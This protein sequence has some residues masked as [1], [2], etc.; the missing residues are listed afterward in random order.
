[1]RKNPL[2]NMSA[3]GG[4]ITSEF[5]EIICGEKVANPKVQPESFETFSAEAPRNKAELDQWIVDSWDRLRERWDSLSN[6]YLKMN[7]SDARSKWIVP[8]FKELGFDPGFI[9]EEIV[10]DGDDKLRFRLSHRGWISAGA[11]MLHMVAPSQD[12]EEANNR[13]EGEVI[14]R[15]RSRSPHDELQAYLN[16]NKS[17]K[18]G[19]VTNGILLR[20]LREYYHTTTKGYVEFDIENIFRERSF[21]DFRAMYRMAHASRFVLQKDG[22]CILEQ[23]YKESR[24]AGVTVGKNLRLNV[25]KAIEALGNGFLT[26]D[27][28][29]KMIADEEFCRAYYSEL[30]HVVY[31]LLF[32][33]FAEQRAMLPTRDSLY[34]EEYSVTRLREISETKRGKDDHLDLW[35]GLKVTFQMLKNGCPELKV[36]G[37]NGSLFDDA[38]IPVLSGLTC[39]NEDLIEAV[40][41]LTM[42]EEERV[43]K[44]I[45]YLDLG[46]EEIG[47]IYESLLDFVPRVFDRAQEVQGEQVAANT[48]FLDPRG[49]NRKTTGS[50]YTPLHLIDELIRTALKPVVEEKLAGAKNKEEA[51]LSIKVCDPACGSGAFLIAANN[52]LAR[53]LAKLYTS[54]TE[55][56]DREIKKATRTILQH[57]I[58]GVDLNPMAVELAKVSLWINS[59]VEDMP[60]NFLD[61]HIKCGNSLVGA[62]PMLLEKGLPAEAFTSVLGDDKI[63]SK[64]IRAINVLEQN[65]KLMVEFNLTEYSTHSKEHALLDEFAEKSPSDVE[66]KKRKYNALLNL[67]DLRQQAL[68]ADAWTAA[69]FWPLQEDSPTPPTQAVLRLV[70]KE[71]NSKLYSETCTM[72]EKLVKHYSFFHWYLEFPDIFEREEIGFDCILGNPPWEKIKIEEREWFIG[73]DDEIANTESKVKRTQLIDSLEKR[74]PSLFSLWV[75]AQ[76]ESQ[77]KASFI[78][79]SGRFPLTA[80]GDTNTF[81]LFSEHGWSILGR[82]GRAGIVVKTGIATD[83]T[84]KEFFGS[85]VDSKAICSLYDFEN[86]ELLFPD[87]APVERFCL[88][89]IASKS[90]PQ[91][92]SDFAFLLSN[93]EQLSDQERRIILT[94]EEIALINPNTK[95]LATFQSRRDAEIVK[96]L[97]RK[98]PVLI[99]ENNNT[100]P[101]NIEYLQIYH[102][103]ADAELFQGNTKEA[104]LERGFTLLPNGIFVKEIERYLP[105]LEAKLFNQLDHRFATFEEVDAENRL[106]RRAGTDQPTIEQKKNADYEIVSRYWVSERDFKLVSNKHSWNHKWAFAFRNITRMTTDTRSAMGTIIPWM[107]MGNSASILLF[108]GEVPVNDALLFTGVFTSI[109]F[110]YILRQKMGGTNLNSF[111]LKQLPAPT[112]SD[113][114]LMNIAKDGYTQCAAT[115]LE[116]RLIKLVWTSKSLDAFATEAGFVGGPFVWDEPERFKLRIEIDATIAKIYGVSKEDFAHIIDSFRILRDKDVS[117]HGSFVTKDELLKEY[118]RISLTE[119]RQGE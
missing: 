21:T 54:Q 90:N 93:T 22:N 55:P 2:S 57:C 7:V 112:A 32:L 37:H 111:I 14:G 74:N 83:D 102:M 16:V 40:R 41:Q 15:G 4:I 24:A 43:L 77:K 76:I 27:I 72:I 31:R 10:V 81:G 42:I 3:H 6:R 115:Y 96:N 68:L 39:K 51:I 49:M 118:D 78:R 79:Q 101:W 47:S 80:V 28:S 116:N 84:W 35:E 56:P 60:L 62:T 104:L 48:F 82:K 95:T 109:I 17:S 88:L 64:K 46:V 36:F 105:L 29:K 33:L 113:L 86:R 119:E 100:N 71:G 114:R 58:Y 45:N 9:K 50:Y 87:V 13:T 25:K 67:P 38:Q 5:L 94:P 34:A 103:T 97:Y 69:F 23:F 53:E 108:R 52:Y 26:P 66:E 75:H 59:C 107:P 117:V 19:I 91:T 98:H 65:Q 18:W 89:T 11:P 85:L 73:R 30:L 1:M 20:I 61:H 12:L 8:L 110:D 70:S 99:D 63:F 106:R 92:K 44:R